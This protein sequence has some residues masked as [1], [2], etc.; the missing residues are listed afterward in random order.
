VSHLRRNQTRISQKDRAGGEAP[1]SSQL[2]GSASTTV[3]LPRS[4]ALS[5]SG[6]EVALIGADGIE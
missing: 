1:L 2:E 3:I 5:N 4:L 6:D